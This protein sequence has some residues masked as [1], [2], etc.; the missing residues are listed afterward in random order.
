[1][2]WF[3]KKKD[4][5][6]VLNGTTHFLILMDNGIRL[7]NDI[8]IRESENLIRTGRYDVKQITHIDRLENSPGLKEGYIAIGWK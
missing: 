6:G 2:N 4:F 7:C 3:L 5:E 8:V 1:M